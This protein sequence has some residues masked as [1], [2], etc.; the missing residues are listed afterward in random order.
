MRERT[1]ISSQQQTTEDQALITLLARFRKMNPED[2][3]ATLSCYRSFAEQISNGIAID[4]VVLPEM[5]PELASK[6][7]G[8]VGGDLH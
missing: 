4:D 3:E 1:N 7:V 5:T 6:I 8:A 2:Q